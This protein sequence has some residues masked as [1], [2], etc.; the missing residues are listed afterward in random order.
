[1]PVVTVVATYFVV[2]WIV[3]FIVLPFGI[4]TQDE[5][6]E[7]TLGTTRSAPVRPRLIRTVIATTIVAAIIVGAGWWAFA[8]FGLNLETIARGGRAQ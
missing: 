1:M 3:L 8:Y 6:G 2:W 4:R 5:A 7:V